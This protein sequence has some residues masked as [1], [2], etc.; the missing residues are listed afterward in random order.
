MISF[1]TKNNFS[2]HLKFA[3]KKIN[4]KVSAQYA[5]MAFRRGSTQELL[6]IGSGIS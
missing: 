1:F 4:F 3:L 6:Q 2:R 5:S